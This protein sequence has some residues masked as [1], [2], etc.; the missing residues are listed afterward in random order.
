MPENS[1][2]KNKDFILDIKNDAQAEMLKRFENDCIYIDSTYV[3][4]A[5]SYEM[6]TLR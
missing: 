2:L 5:C 4:N 1:H 3:T 6:T